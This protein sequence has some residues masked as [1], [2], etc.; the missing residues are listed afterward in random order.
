MSWEVEHLFDR[1]PPHPEPMPTLATIFVAIY[2]RIS[3]DAQAKGLGVRD[4]EQDCRKLAE[5]L[6]WIVYRV[7]VDNDIRAAKYS[8]K[9]RP[10]YLE[11]LQ[12]MREGVVQAV[13]C[14]DVYRLV[15]QPKELEEFLDIAEASGITRLG[16]VSGDYDLSTPEGRFQ[17]R[18]WANIAANESEK[19]SQRHRRRQ[20]QIAMDGQPNGGQ[21]RYGY[22]H[23][24]GANRLEV[25]PDEAVIIREMAARVLAGE[26]ISRIARDLNRR[27]I[28]AAKGG[29][30]VAHTVR[31]V[32]SGDTVAGI[33]VHRGAVYPA[34]WEPIL[35]RSTHD[36]L[37]LLFKD[38]ARRFNPGG[39]TKHHWVGT[40]F[41][42]C[43][44]KLH[45]RY[46]KGQKTYCCQT[47]G[48]VHR[49]AEPVEAYL[50][51]VLFERT[52]HPEFRASLMEHIPDDEEHA[53]LR[54]QR[55]EIDIQ[56]RELGAAR[57]APPPG[58]KPL[59]DDVY[60]FAAARLDA[61]L[62]AIDRRLQEIIARSAMPVGVDFDDL[63]DEWEGL[64]LH[65]KRR[66]LEFVFRRVVLLPVGRLGRAERFRDP[67]LLESTIRVEFAR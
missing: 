13:L 25:V 50:E 37:V 9:P 41:C 40:L 11:M 7:F 62:Q 36:A 44:A 58:R 23:I 19:T 45:V 32:V 65:T 46:T 1:K 4:Q 34:K 15:R 49:L 67:E 10:A 39:P 20:L 33:R 5:R 52:Q 21:R 17:A 2:V 42:P 30:W 54:Q 38:P 18:L 43:N 26:T 66:I 24:E 57:F 31:T 51:G 3:K 53:A 12:A 47:C 35:D 8:N 6:G 22:R 59:D 63:E 48:K 14:W 27:G 16:T 64:P 28:P 56:R 61:N 29:E 55:A 60:Q